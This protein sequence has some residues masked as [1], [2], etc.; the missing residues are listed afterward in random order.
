M[1]DIGAILERAS[2]VEIDGGDRNRDDGRDLSTRF[3][4]TVYGVKMGLHPN[5]KID[6]RLAAYHSEAESNAQF[7]PASFFGISGFSPVPAGKLDDETFKLNVDFNDPFGKG[8]SFNAEYF[9]IGADY[10]SIMAARREADVLLTEGSD[11]AFYFPGPGNAAFGVFG[12][13]GNKSDGYGGWSGP[14]QQVAT[15]NVD[16]EFT[17]FDE[18]MAETVIGW[19]GLTIAPLWTIG[20]LDL[21]GEL[22]LI[23]YNTNW[24]AWG[25]PSF[26]IQNSVYPNMDSDA[27]VFGSFRNAYNPFQDRQ[28]TIA[29]VKFKY[30][31]DAGKGVELFGKL[32]TMDDQDD[33]MTDAR[34]LPYRAGDCPGGA[35]ACAGNRNFYS[36]GNTTA[37]IY[38]NPGLVTIGGVTGYQWKPF[39]NVRDDDK[40]LDYLMLQLGA[41]YQLTDDLWAQFTIERYDA[42]LKDGNTAFQA[43]QLH[44]MASGAHKKNKLI[45]SGRYIL[46][47]A[48]FGMQWAYSSGTFTP[49]FG[50]GF[51]PQLAD[52]GI[53]D[54]FGYR[55]GTNGFRGRFGGWNSLEK[56]DF[57][58]HNLKAWM[59]VQF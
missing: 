11:G 37:E 18:P 12:G 25:R 21:S 16:N 50:T 43:Y 47:G 31:L 22:T 32:K 38:G 4:N 44:E 8:L 59:K 36:P 33:R 40:K 13:E 49:D 7:A 6:A 55:V 3:E 34:F 2:D 54:E 15:I 29:L 19:K 30:L 26:P 46:A 58:E 5:A 42:D 57:K 20:N 52:Q 48:E 23:D 28:T 45:L 24:Q 41:N 9:D 35:T 10:A 51:V 53:Q 1:F 17:D 39:D 27:G 56:R 14:A